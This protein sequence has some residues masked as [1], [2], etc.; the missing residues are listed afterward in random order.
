MTILFIK[1]IR[2]QFLIPNLLL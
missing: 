1:I 2:I